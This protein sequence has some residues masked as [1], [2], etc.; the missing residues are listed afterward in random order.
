MIFWFTSVPRKFVLM[1]LA[2]VVNFNLTVS[3]VHI[4]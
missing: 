3:N 1:A 2:V 4:G